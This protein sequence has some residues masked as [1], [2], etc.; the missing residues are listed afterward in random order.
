MLC[1]KCDVNTATTHIRTIV[2][3]E[4]YEKH[5]CA[6]CAANEGYGD[7]K[8]NNLTEILSSMFGDTSVVDKKKIT[9]CSCCGSAFSD[10]AKSGKCGCAQCYTTFY[11]QLLPYFKRVHGS[12]QHIGKVPQVSSIPDTAPQESI[13]ELR[14]LLNRLVREENYEQAA[15]VRDKIKKMEGEAL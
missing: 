10:I 6:S 9:R 2:N 3:G 11:E 12:T 7:I 8:N 1:E 5:L 15:V 14:S 13:A 4:V